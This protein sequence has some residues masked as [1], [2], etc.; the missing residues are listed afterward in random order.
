[1]RH[2]Q[3]HEQ[4]GNLFLVASVISVVASACGGGSAVSGLHAGEDGGE[5][6]GSG[7]SSGIIGNFGDAT[8]ANDG[9]LSADSGCATASAQATRAP[10]Y[11]LF[12]LDGSGSM[13]QERKWTAV[14]P[15]LQSIF[16]DMNKAADPG[17]GV[18]LIVFSDSQDKSDGKGPYPEPAIDVPIGFVGAAQLSSLNARLSGIPVWATPTQAAMTGA[19]GELEGFVPLTPLPPGGQKV[20]ILITDGVPTDACAPGTGSTYNYATNTCVEMAATELAKASPQGP[21]LT[22]VIGVGD[23][24]STKLKDF[25]PNFLGNVAST[26]GTG[27]TGCMTNDNTTT[28]GLCYFEGRPIESGH[29]LRS[30][31]C[32]SRQPSMPSG[33]KS[34]LAHSR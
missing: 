14:V 16:T 31:R 19:Y 30:C 25:D 28:S 4:D 33:A 27:P 24:P 32:R 29:R 12:V 13:V 2:T 20:M 8:A 11:M 18:G 3:R 10:V 6:E 5:N 9:A 21:I 34:S 22:F 15:A 26:G 17:E 7:S 1:M 23:F